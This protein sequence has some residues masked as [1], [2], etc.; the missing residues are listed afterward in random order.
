MGTF[1]AHSAA[2]CSESS[3]SA[4]PCN[5]SG[6][7]PYLS[8]VSVA[9]LCPKY[10]LPDADARADRKRCR[11]VTKFVGRQPTRRTGVSYRLAPPPTPDIVQ[12]HRATARIWEGQRAEVPAL[13]VIAEGVDEELGKRNGAGLM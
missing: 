4:T 13:K 2:A 9:D 12:A 7:R 6:K 3:R 10:F 1:W 8:K 5:S 11:R